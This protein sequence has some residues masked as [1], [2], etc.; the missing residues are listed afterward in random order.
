MTNNKKVTTI[1]SGATKTPDTSEEV[2]Q[3]FA[4]FFS[5]VDNSEEVR[6]VVEENSKLVLNAGDTLSL[7][8]FLVEKHKEDTAQQMQVIV[9]KVGVLESILLDKLNISDDELEEYIDQYNE[10]TK[11][12]LQAYQEA[13]KSKEVEPDGEE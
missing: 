2:L 1:K 13:Q 10:R 5:F 8:N 6:K 11:E 12:L 4:K 3:A 9:N 7:V